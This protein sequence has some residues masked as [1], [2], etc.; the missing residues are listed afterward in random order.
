MADWLANLYQKRVSRSLKTLYT[1]G[2]LMGSAFVLY[3]DLYPARPALWAF[4]LLFG[5]GLYLHRRAEKGAWHRRYLDYRA[6]AEG[7]R[8]QVYWSMA[9]LSS[10]GAG[11]F[12]HD[13]F[14]QKQDVELSWIRHV[15]RTAAIKSDATSGEVAVRQPDGI[16]FASREWIGSE[17]SGQI[18]YYSSRT[19]QRSRR[20]ALTQ[21]VGLLALWAG[22]AL[23]LMLAITGSHLPDGWHDAL[24]FS[25][26]ALT[27]AAAVRDAYAFRT[28]DRELVKQYRFMHKIFSN[29]RRRLD[30]ATSDTER[31][32]VLRAL[33][34]AS[35]DEHTEWILMHRER[36]PEHGKF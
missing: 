20:N 28:A 3:S 21:R 30:A 29:A 32:G 15:M 14:L 24:L 4:L 33:G 6:L 18:G 5:V 1:L 35:L 10:P 13:V 8:V 36:P 26:G 25:I 34:D 23:A 17:D 11:R 22:I 27:L 2:F 12:A 19:V 16:E 31:R 7:L 9:G